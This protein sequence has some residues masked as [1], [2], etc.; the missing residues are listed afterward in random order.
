MTLDKALCSN[1]CHSLSL[2]YSD[3]Q[4]VFKQLKIASITVLL[5]FTL[6]RDLFEVTSRITSV[7]TN[8]IVGSICNAPF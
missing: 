5:H 4:S 3:A 1:C 6:N 2:L 8:N 7:Q